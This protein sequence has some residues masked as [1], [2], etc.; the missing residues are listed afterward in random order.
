MNVPLRSSCLGA[1]LYRTSSQYNVQLL[2]KNPFQIECCSWLQDH[3]RSKHSS[4]GDLLVCSANKRS[5]SK[6]A[7]ATDTL[8]ET[9]IEPNWRFAPSSQIS[10]HKTSKAKDIKKRRGRAES[11][12]LSPS[13]EKFLADDW[14]GDDVVA[15]E[16][17]PIKR[18]Q[19]QSLYALLPQQQEE[20]NA[21]SR[22]SQQE[23]EAFEAFADVQNIRPDLQGLRLLP[24]EDE[25]CRPT[26]QDIDILDD[27][28]EPAKWSNEPDA[29]DLSSSGAMMPKVDDED[30][31]HMNTVF[32]SACH[33][34]SGTFNLSDYP[35]LP[36]LKGHQVEAIES[37]IENMRQG[38]KRQLISMP[39]GAGKTFTFCA[40]ARVLHCRTIIL[41]HREQLV[42]Q[43]VKAI[44]RVWP[45]VAVGVVKAKR[46]EHD[47]PIVVAMVQTA[48]GV[49]RLNKLKHGLGFGLCIVDEAH[50]APAT[51]YQAVLQEL[52]FLNEDSSKL[53][54]GVTATAT[55]T[56]KSL[57]S[58]TFQCLS[59]DLTIGQLIRL[60]HLSQV[61][62]R[63]ILTHTDIS[64]VEVQPVAGSGAG[65]VGNEDEITRDFNDRILSLVINTPQRNM[66]VVKSYLMWAP[67]RR[68]VAFCVSIEHAEDLACM[69]QSQGVSADFL[70]S[71]RSA[72]EQREVME[73]HKRGE[74][75]ILTNV[76]I[77]TEGYDDPDISCVL[78]TRPTKSHG[79]YTQCVGRG[80]RLG[81]PQKKDCLILDFTDICHVLDHPSDLITINDILDESVL[82]EARE[83]PL[84]PPD[85]E[86]ALKGILMKSGEMTLYDTMQY[87]WLHYSN[88]FYLPLTDMAD[89]D[90]DKSQITMCVRPDLETQGWQLCY[91]RNKERKIEGSGVWSK[92]DWMI[93][94]TVTNLKDDGDV[95]RRAAQIAEVNMSK[96]LL[97]KH[98]GSKKYDAAL[99][100]K[101][102]DRPW[103]DDPATEYQIKSLK[104]SGITDEMLSSWAVCSSGGKLA[105]EPENLWSV[106][107][108]GTASDA[109]SLIRLTEQ[110]GVHTVKKP[111]QPATPAQLNYLKALTDEIPPLLAAAQ[112]LLDRNPSPED[113]QAQAYD[114]EHPYLF[115][116]MGSASDGWTSQETLAEV[117][118]LI[119]Q[120]G[121]SGLDRMEASRIIDRLVRINKW[122]KN[123]TKWKAV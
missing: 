43:T 88:A 33:V 19:D 53:L 49:K 37:V 8:T 87:T 99:R 50:H 113:D 1:C 36:M 100:S 65:I 55:R 34:P 45:G 71:K 94:D 64:G 78:M 98:F 72:E 73:K 17:A 14:H 112:D 21:S 68:A 70:H 51:T 85:K 23:E 5:S 22:P 95:L 67:T 118:D 96:G 4:L 26:S 108:K 44:Q 102:R 110:L 79:L 59:F 42:E 75:H 109:L 89:K 41:V 123:I 32:G 115:G 117:S 93:L 63:R 107:S 30:L 12:E 74:I 48:S 104:A 31:G 69:F 54:V 77:L 58:D 111:K 97:K 18:A 7:T 38:K 120:A 62:A 86:R 81:G 15:N 82:L 52:G 119:Q 46:D 121:A 76:N 40:L 3:A 84:M 10:K 80:L 39:T 90:N 16:G 47:K 24:E 91:A 13:P 57:L 66:L 56:D 61:R 35:G 9:Q 105:E 92:S 83:K 60:G 29:F 103:R 6:E 106:I 20:N 11:S 25:A 28:L 27:G 116:E 114:D 2:L 101:S 122:L